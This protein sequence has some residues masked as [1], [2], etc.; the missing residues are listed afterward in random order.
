MARTPVEEF[1][2]YV[3]E[4]SRKY[5]ALIEKAPIKLSRFAT[6]RR[7]RLL[8]QCLRAAG[9]RIIEGEISD[10]GCRLGNGYI[11]AV[12]PASLIARFSNFREFRDYVLEA[13]RSN[14]DLCPGKVREKL[15]IEAVGE[16]GQPG[17]A[18]GD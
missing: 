16:A 2:R 6:G 12:V 15:G 5:G 11:Y 8:A 3:W 10:G 14:G 4:F 7:T 1:L 18:G 9:F 17:E 13:L